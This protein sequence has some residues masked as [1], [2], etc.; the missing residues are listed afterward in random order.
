MNAFEKKTTMFRSRSNTNEYLVGNLVRIHTQ[1]K[2][3]GAGI[4]GVDI[5]INLQQTTLDTG[6]RTIYKHIKLVCRARRPIPPQEPTRE[7]DFGDSDNIKKEERADVPAEV[8]RELCEQKQGILEQK[9]EN[10]E[11]RKAI[12][13]MS[14]KFT[15]QLNMIYELLENEYE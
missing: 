7:T 8:A 3:K 10:K 12:E 9:Q 11:L 14:S 6:F 13:D 15:L 4:E 5:K 1:S 2:S